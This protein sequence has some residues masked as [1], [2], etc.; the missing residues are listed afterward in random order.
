[1]NYPLQFSVNIAFDNE[2][3]PDTRPTTWGNAAYA[4]TP[5]PFVNIPKGKKVR[6]LRWD[7]DFYAFIHGNAPPGTHAG[8]LAGILTQAKLV[9]GIW[10]AANQPSPY[11]DP[12]V[13]A[14]AGCPLFVCHSVGADSSTCRIPINV[15]LSAGGLL[16]ES[17]F[18]MRQALFL[19]DTGLPIHM[20]M[21][22]VVSFQYE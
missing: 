11:V 8:L 13:Q 4:D 9:N 12:S 19:N 18:L 14:S 10:Q 2:G 21:T 3:T 6:L 16:D 22:G 5:V 20:E 17:V 15:D 7:G 1:M